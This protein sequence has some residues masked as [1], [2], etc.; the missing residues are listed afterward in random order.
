MSK[1]MELPTYGYNPFILESSSRTPQPSCSD[2]RGIAATS[3]SC[4]DQ[5]EQISLAIDRKQ[6]DPSL[7]LE[8]K[9]RI[10][11]AVLVAEIGRKNLPGRFA[12]ARV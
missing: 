7:C 12:N 5:S 1:T 3:P 4:S 8:N 2:L 6:V 11:L 9:C 10:P